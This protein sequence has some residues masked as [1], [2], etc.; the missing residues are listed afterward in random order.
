MKDNLQNIEGFGYQIPPKKEWVWAYFQQ[1]G[2]S[3]LLILQFFDFMERSK[4]MTTSGT[5]IRDWKKAAFS[6][7]CN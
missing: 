5:P 6:W 7:L 4:W 3:E 2:A 1:K